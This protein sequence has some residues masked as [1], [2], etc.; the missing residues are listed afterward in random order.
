MR[1]PPQSQAFLPNYFMTT[2][3]IENRK[4]SHT[5]QFAGELAPMAPSMAGVMQHQGF[6]PEKYTG[7]IHHPQRLDSDRLAL[8]LEVALIASLA[9]PAP[10]AYEHPHAGRSMSMG[11][12]PEVH[13]MYAY[14]HPSNQGK[15][16]GSGIRPRVV[17]G[18]ISGGSVTKPPSSAPS[19]GYFYAAARL[20]LQNDELEGAHSMRWNDLELID[21]RR[22]IRIERTQAG[23]AIQVQISVV[24]LAVENPHPAPS[25]AGV[26]VVEVSC[27][28]KTNLEGGIPAGHYI[29]SVEVVSIVETLI[30]AE[31]LDATL[32][33]RER[34]RIRSNLLPFWQK[35]PILRKKI[36]DGENDDENDFAR[37]I[38]AYK[39]RRPRGFDKGVRVLEWNLLGA[40]LERA[41]QCY[42]VETPM[43]QA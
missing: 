38:M 22:I 33:R 26:S 11:A 34:G 17:R 21:G 15:Q 20:M 37:R 35:R 39:I 40:A 41:L 24:G 29:T 10:P 6:V 42:Y 2:W 1:I 43:A 14:A 32:R 18:S 19:P 13:R 5:P 27:L 25:S 12:Y 16:P 9:D 8:P 28:N 4:V 31:D 23:A 36:D 30:G 7:E 3:P